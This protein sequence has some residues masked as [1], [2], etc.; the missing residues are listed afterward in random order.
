MIFFLKRSKIDDS[1]LKEIADGLGF[2]INL[3]KIE[4]NILGYN[5]Y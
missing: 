3:V 2:L 4:L 1:C 5:N